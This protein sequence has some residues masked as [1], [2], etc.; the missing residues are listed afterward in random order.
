M[1]TDEH[2]VVRWK[3]INDSGFAFKF[4]AKTKEQVVEKKGNKPEKY[5]SYQA[6][7][8]WDGYLL[9]PFSLQ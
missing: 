8:T 9:V 7:A 1:E 4:N 3:E 6:Y 5:L 2:L